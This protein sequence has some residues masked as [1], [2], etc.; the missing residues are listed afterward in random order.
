MAKDQVVDV[1]EEP[2]EEVTET[3]VRVIEAKEGIMGKMRKNWKIIAAA[4]A[5]GVVLVGAKLLKGRKSDQDYESDEFDEEGFGD[6]FDEASP[7]D[8]PV[9][10]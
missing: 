4:A 10:E 8:D 3:K 9:D 2:I 5:A 1:V 6:D 7:I